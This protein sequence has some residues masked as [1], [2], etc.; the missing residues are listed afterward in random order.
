MLYLIS[1]LWLNIYIYF[2]FYYFFFCFGETKEETQPFF[3]LSF[4]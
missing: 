1:S 3:F 4:H 2:S